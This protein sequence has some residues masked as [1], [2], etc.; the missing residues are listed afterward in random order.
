MV[1]SFLEKA[2]LYLLILPLYSI[3]GAMRAFAC[4]DLPYLTVSD[5]E[6]FT[7]KVKIF[8]EVYCIILGRL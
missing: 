6:F 7:N 5:V 3:I 4:A 8:R 2:L 1:L